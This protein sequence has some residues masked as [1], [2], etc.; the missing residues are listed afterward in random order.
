MD[1]HLDDEQIQPSSK[2]GCI[3]PKSKIIISVSII[4]L[5]VIVLIIVILVV[6]LKED[7]EKNKTIPPEMD[8]SDFVI[9]NDIIPE[10]VT[11]LRYYSSF[12][13]AGV[14][15]DGYEEPVALMTKEAVEKLKNVSKYFDEKGYRIKIWD[16]Y[17]PQRAVDHFIRWGQNESDDL[18][19]PYFYPDLTKKQ[20]F[21]GGYIAKHSGHSKG[22]TIDMTLLHKINGTDVDFGSGFDFFGSKANFNYTNVTDEQKENRI[23]LNRIMTE[24]GFNALP[25]EWWHFTLKNEPFP[26]TYFNFPINATIIRLGINNYN[27]TSM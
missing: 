13:F 8:F 16:S 19:K 1:Y 14:H 2:I 12:N 23:M 15:I 6:T 5:L 4:A 18:M 9:I 21:D 27:F 17:R 10:I 11:E 20:V 25:E 24:N 22:S 3:T 26:N 7:S